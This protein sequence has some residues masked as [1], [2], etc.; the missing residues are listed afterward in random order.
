MATV[1]GGGGGRVAAA[2]AREDSGAAGEK[3]RARGDWMARDPAR[4]R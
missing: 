1:R 2:V 4:G 3:G